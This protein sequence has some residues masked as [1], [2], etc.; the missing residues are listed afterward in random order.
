MEATLR[1]GK[2]PASCASQ[3]I[4]IAPTRGE[5][6]ATEPPASAQGGRRSEWKR[7]FWATRLPREPQPLQ[8]RLQPRRYLPRLSYR[9]SGR[10]TR[11]PLW[12]ES[13]FLLPRV[14]ASQ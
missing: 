5:P 12:R 4:T 13:E 7:L 1:R 2:R 11:F 9:T 8:V 10:R 3:V 14:Q 6:A